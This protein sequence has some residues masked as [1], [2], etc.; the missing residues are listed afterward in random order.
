MVRWG[1]T[2]PST[3]ADWLALAVHN[4][5][6]R[7]ADL[8]ISHNFDQR[9]P[10]LHRQLCTHV[11]TN[12][13]SDFMEEST[14]SVVRALIGPNE[15]DAK[16]DCIIRFRQ[17]ELAPILEQCR[18][19]GREKRKDGSSNTDSDTHDKARLFALLVLRHSSENYSPIVMKSAPRHK[20]EL[21]SRPLRESDRERS[22]TQ[23]TKMK[24]DAKSFKRTPM[25]LA[26]LNR[27]ASEI[28]L[29]F[30]LIETPVVKFENAI[31]RLS[32]RFEKV[33]ASE[34]LQEL[35]CFILWFV[36]ALSVN[37][38]K[39]VS[40]FAPKTCLIVSRKRLTYLMQIFGADTDPSS[41]RAILLKARRGPS[42]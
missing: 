2:Y 19:M 6:V 37:R 42:L 5:T 23:L 31:W 11:D 39:S 25:T 20:V 12:P 41:R 26:Q 21:R 15:T 27:A 13:H 35:R 10:T 30:L 8:D 3:R 22:R 1:L 17:N 14:F 18:L 29:A 34:L 4:V 32:L 24:E 38:R 36:A 40:V 7:D 16:F 28:K 9:F 33:L